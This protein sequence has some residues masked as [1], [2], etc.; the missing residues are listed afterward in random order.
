MDTGKNQCEIASELYEEAINSM[1]KHYADFQFFTERDIVWTIQTHL[2]KEISKRDL[3]LKIYDNYRVPSKKLIDLVI[4]DKETDILLV[5]AEFKYEPDHARVDITPGKLNPSKAFW[6]SEK[7][8][9]VVQ[10]IERIKEL[11]NQSYSKTGYITFIDEGGHH[12]Y[13]GEPDS[14]IWCEEGKSP[15]SDKTLCALLFKFTN[16]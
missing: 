1:L 13:Q 4:I 16:I 12:R 8:H 14:C 2:I 7:N 15:Y 9:G 10:D 6:D 5:A 3:P 11:V